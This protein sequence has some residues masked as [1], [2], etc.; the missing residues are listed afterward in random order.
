MRPHRYRDARRAFLEQELVA[1]IERPITV[2]IPMSNIIDMRCFECNG[3]FKVH[4]FRGDS[5]EI[6]EGCWYYYQP[7]NYCD[8]TYG[9]EQVCAGC[10]T[11]MA[12]GNGT[13]WVK[14]S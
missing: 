14:D 6:Y 10:C 9:I 13:Y 11:V 5:G 3:Q 8:G 2:S 7:Y 4:E 1:T 12:T